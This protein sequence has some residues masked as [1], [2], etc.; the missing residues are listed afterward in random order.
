MS[1]IFLAL[2]CYTECL[3]NSSPFVVQIYCRPT[4]AYFEERLLSTNPVKK[5]ALQNY[6]VRFGFTLV[7]I[8]IITLVASA[9]PFFGDFVAICGAIG[10]TPLDFVFPILAHLKA[11]RKPQ[12]C[13][14]LVLLLNITIAT[15]FSIVMVLGCIGAVRFIVE[16]IKTYRFF[17]DM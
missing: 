10:F 1:M 2:K 5:V 14:L 17:H 11:G 8:S 3:T 15:W 6:L 13:H 4:Y 12:K 9:V 16:D 7:Y